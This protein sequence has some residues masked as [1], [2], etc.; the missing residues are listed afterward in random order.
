MILSRWK[1]PSKH[2][3]RCAI[4]YLDNSSNNEPRK[5]SKHKANESSIHSLFCFVYSWTI[6]TD[7][8]IDLHLNRMIYKSKYRHCSSDTYN[9]L[10]NSWDK[11]RNIWEG[12]VSSLKTCIRN[13][14]H[15]NI[16]IFCECLTSERNKTKKKAECTKKN[17]LHN[18][19]YMCKLYQIIEK[20]TNFSHPFAFMM[21]FHILHGYRTLYL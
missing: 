8:T 3:L 9:K 2:N 18:W 15:G 1:R 16:V 4:K 11:N 20:K 5:N 12:K 21:V 6:S 10:D 13:E 17:F 7:S 19:N 14:S